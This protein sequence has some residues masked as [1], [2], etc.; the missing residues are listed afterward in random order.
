M[1]TEGLELGALLGRDRQGRGQADSTL[2]VTVAGYVF[3]DHTI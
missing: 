2:E 3:C 1:N